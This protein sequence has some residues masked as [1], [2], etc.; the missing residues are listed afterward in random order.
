[1]KNILNIEIYAIIGINTILLFLIL[2]L[3][4]IRLKTLNKC[5]NN[6][7]SDEK[8]HKQQKYLT[9]IMYSLTIIFYLISNFLLY[10]YMK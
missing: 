5:V 7:F 10:K 1:M 2:I 6:I 8:L 3:I 4:H 9:F